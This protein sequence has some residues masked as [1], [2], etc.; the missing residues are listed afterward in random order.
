M[1]KFHTAAAAS[2]LQTLLSACVL[3]NVDK[4]ENHVLLKL[5]FETEAPDNR[6][7]QRAAL[8]LLA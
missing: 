5:C 8:S 6:A 1:L 4:F 2:L 7:L 3:T